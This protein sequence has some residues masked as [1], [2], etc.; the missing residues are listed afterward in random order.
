MFSQLRLPIWLSAIQWFVVLFPFVVFTH[1]LWEAEV[2]TGPSV[3]I[4][5][6]VAKA[7]LEDEPLSLMQLAGQSTTPRP[8]ARRS[9]ALEAAPEVP[10]S[11]GYSLMQ[12]KAQL[13]GARAVSQP[14]KADPKI[15][16]DMEDADED[17][18]EA[19]DSPFC[20]GKRVLCS[21]AAFRVELSRPEPATELLPPPLKQGVPAPVV[22]PA[23]PESP[24]APAKQLVDESLA[25][26][27][28]EAEECATV[29]GVKFCRRRSLT[30]G[31]A[32]VGFGLLQT[33]FRNA[34]LLAI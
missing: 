24:L 26:S 22:Q 33:G 9:R 11:S 18:D 20:G 13:Q 16:V 6:V 15:V 1:A 5:G 10:A 19:D 14:S 34:V 4:Q 2:A 7:A 3:A 28:E 30:V 25:D 12:R 32:V 29:F 27:F 8:N 17:W 23:R 21:P 31:A